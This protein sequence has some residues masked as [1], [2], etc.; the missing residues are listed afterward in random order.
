MTRATG[1]VCFLPVLAQ[2][3]QMPTPPISTAPV[4]SLHRRFLLL[5]PAGYAI[6]GC[7]ACT[8]GCRVS[9]SPSSSP[10][11]ALLDLLSPRSPVSVSLSLTPPLS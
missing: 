4:S 9:P 10:K 3:E 8:R 2:P 11:L 1:W 7:D 6:R 5:L